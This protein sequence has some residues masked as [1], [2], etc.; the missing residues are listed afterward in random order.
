MERTPDTI[1]K[2]EPLQHIIQE[3]HANDNVIA[4]ILFGSVAR[5]QAHEYSDIDLSIIARTAIPV[6]EQMD[7][8]SYG[9]R[10][11]DLSLF[12]LLPVTIRFRVI[13]EGKVLFCKDPLQLH[14]IKIKTVR[15]YLDIAPFIRRHCRHAMV[16]SLI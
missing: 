15:E 16:F 1:P 6:S 13:R 10:K 8:L 2:T 14:R 12:H 5:G 7:L 11:I 3:L 9:C 4:L